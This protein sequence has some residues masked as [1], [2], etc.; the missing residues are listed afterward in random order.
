M[1]SGGFEFGDLWAAYRGPGGENC[2]HAHVAVQVAIVGDASPRIAL[3]DGSINGPML[4]IG[5]LVTH[6][7]VPETRSLGLLYV[8]PQAPLAAALLASIH[9]ARAAAAPAALANAVRG[10]MPAHW[11]ARL[12]AATGAEA[13]V[14]DA[15]L[16][17]ALRTAAIDGAPGAVARAAAAVGLSEPR[18]RAIAR[19]QL[20]APLS[21]WLLWRKLEQAARAV[22]AGASLAAAAA[23][24]GF[25]D[26][27]HFARTM[28]RMF[29]VT[30][31][32]AAS[33]LR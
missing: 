30:P 32:V 33:A 18:L 12:S 9:P 19:L 3:A 24:G 8:A 7:L 17:A 25:A 6:R 22:A 28:K 16:A 29:G 20:G 21:Q 4:I 10:T 5:P 31:A 26:Q 13:P 23:D 1:W 27:A 2:A 15:R 11:A 14:V